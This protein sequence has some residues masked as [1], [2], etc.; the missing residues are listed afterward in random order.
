MRIITILYLVTSVC[1]GQGLYI[2]GSTVSIAANT[3]FAVMGNAQNEG[4]LINNGDFQISGTWQNDGMYDAASGGFTLSSSGDQ[5]INHN[6]QSFSKLSITGGGKKFFLADLEI[7]QELN[8][9]DGHLVSQNESR[10]YATNTLIVLGGSDL[11]HVVGEYVSSGTGAK[12]FPVGDGSLY[13]PITISSTSE[14]LLGASAVS[15]NPVLT[16]D[17]SLTEISK[18]H[19]WR[20]SFENGESRSIIIELPDNGQSSFSDPSVAFS[21]DGFPYRAVSP[22]AL[23]NNLLVSDAFVASPGL[24]T[25]G[26]S[27]SIEK[28][29]ALKVYNLLT[30]NGDGLHD[31]LKVENI[32]FYPN[33][34]VSVFN[35]WGDQLF[36]V[37]GYD[38]LQKIFDGKSDSTNKE[39]SDGTY[40][41]VI[42]DGAGKRYT[43][44]FVMR[45]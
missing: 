18:Q 29:P 15:P 9:V 41:Y 2:K 38:N 20:L 32:E 28:L 12:L 25:L 42:D 7:L 6:A 17:N 19:A 14:A 43:G 27:S 44:F 36:E 13:L 1:N 22:L 30:P 11:S 4:T 26:I 8:L 37:S 24:I 35:R 16:F 45:N 40:F 3:V 10:I 34:K 5:I 21:P 23:Q 33:N 39:L 31:F